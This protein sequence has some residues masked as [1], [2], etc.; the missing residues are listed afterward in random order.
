MQ[1]VLSKLSELTSCKFHALDK[2][3]CTV[4]CAGLAHQILCPWPKAPTPH[5]VGS[6]PEAAQDLDNVKQIDRPAQSS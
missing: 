4:K 6:K 5:H 1:Q 3:T 2:F